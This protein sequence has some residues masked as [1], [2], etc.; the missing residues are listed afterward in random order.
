[1]IDKTI[2]LNRVFSGM[3]YLDKTYPAWI[4]AFTLEDILMLD[5]NNPNDCVLAV[6]ARNIL[7]KDANFYNLKNYWGLSYENVS[8]LGFYPELNTKPNLD[9]DIEYVEELNKVWIA[10]LMGV[11]YANL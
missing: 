10:M 6:L 2:V 11:R 4:Y 8:E 7:G 9:Y 1:M 3:N 5:I